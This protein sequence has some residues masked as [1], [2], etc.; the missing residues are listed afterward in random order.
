MKV[1]VYYLVVM[2][3]VDGVGVEDVLGWKEKMG[4]KFLGRRKWERP[5]LNRKKGR[6]NC[7]ADQGEYPAEK[8][9]FDQVRARGTRAQGADTHGTGNRSEYAGPEGLGKSQRKGD[10]SARGRRRRVGSWGRRER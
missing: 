8:G 1:Y 2:L 5:D 3:G 6:A 10:G 4:R 9:E 7:Q